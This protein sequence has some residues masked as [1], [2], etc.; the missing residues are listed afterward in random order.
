MSERVQVI[1]N[2]RSAEKAKLIR[3][4]G[5]VPAVL[6]SHGVTSQIEIEKKT[7]LSL[8]RHGISEST[9]LDLKLGNEIS[10]VFIKDYEVDPVTSELLHLDF[11]KVTFG[12]KI[13]THIPIVLVGKPI[14]VK[15][16]G[17]L[18]TFLSDIEVEILPRNLVPSISVDI[19]ELN[20]GDALHIGDLQLPESAKVFL[21][22]D[23]S[24]C[25]ISVSAK[26]ESQE[27]DETKEE[28]ET[29]TDDKQDSVEQ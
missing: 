7:V 2:K 25:H 12:E 19:S 23:V 21:T 18:E 9:L 27:S 22:N 14:G 1:V 17:V 11:F 6:Y 10:T 26:L 20:I 8:F 3:K 5:F 24:I 13:R 16:G 29:T 28:A 15:Q 4:R